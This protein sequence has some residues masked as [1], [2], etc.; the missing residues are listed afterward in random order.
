MFKLCFALVAVA[1]ALDTEA[2]TI[3]MDMSEA[4][5][6]AFPTKFSMECEVGAR[7]VLPKQRGYDTNDKV[8]TVSKAIVRNYNDHTKDGSAV[9]S[10][11]FNRRG[12]YTFTYRAQDKASNKAEP[13][14]FKLKIV[15]TLVSN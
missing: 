12:V 11:D 15:G 7:C 14:V 10:V 13:L 5:G 8:V 2:P 9:K 3:S 1:S 6:S 4:V